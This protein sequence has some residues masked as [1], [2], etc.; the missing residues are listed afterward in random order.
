MSFLC[1]DPF[2]RQDSYKA[3]NKPPMQKKGWQHDPIRKSSHMTNKTV[4][5]LCKGLTIK[6]NLELL[7]LILHR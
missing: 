3:E 2:S 7:G 1:L 6:R 4:N 5:R